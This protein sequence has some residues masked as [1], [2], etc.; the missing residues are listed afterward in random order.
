[1]NRI[2]ELAGLSVLAPTLLENT[3]AGKQAGAINIVMGSFKEIS[4]MH[5][6]DFKK[7]LVMAYEAGFSDGVKHEHALAVKDKAITG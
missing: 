4:D 3:G 6:K 5:N 1:M 2:L 7:A